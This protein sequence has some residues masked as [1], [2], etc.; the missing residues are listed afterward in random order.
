[1]KVA[2]ACEVEGGVGKRKHR[3]RRKHYALSTLGGR[4]T[5]GLRLC[6]VHFINTSGYL[7]LYWYFSGG[8]QVRLPV[9]LTTS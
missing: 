5:E 2:A 3:G 4:C 7:T 6:H 9:L 8:R 1:M